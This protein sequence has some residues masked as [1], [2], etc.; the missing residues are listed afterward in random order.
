MK[1]KLV[2]LLVIGAVLIGLA[3]CRW[4]RSASSALESSAPKVVDNPEA[5]SE[6]VQEAAVKPLELPT[7]EVGGEKK[8]P[9]PIVKLGEPLEVGPVTFLVKAYSL[10]YS[11]ARRQL[12]DGSLSQEA[13]PDWAATEFRITVENRS[14]GVLDLNQKKA[15]WI[16]DEDNLYKRYGFD[17][18]INWFVVGYINRY[19]I[20]PEER[21]AEAYN[22][23][24]M[25]KA[26]VA[27]MVNEKKIHPLPDKVLPG[28]T[29]EGSVVLTRGAEPNTYY[30]CFGNW[31]RKLAWGCVDLGTPEEMLRAAVVNI[32]P[33]PPTPWAQDRDIR[34][35]GE[36][37]YGPEGIEGA[38]RKLH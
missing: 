16:M 10:T 27:W 12:P 33:N 29:V 5:A 30:L 3:G 20:I 31:L 32:G 36:N 8:T 15:Y 11:V 2:A 26:L 28:H 34:I 21:V 17:P 35:S 6:P 22:Y 14:D 25:D 13:E 37:G 4:G 23:M 18:V 38:G 24:P 1:R 7:Y 9:V 19:L